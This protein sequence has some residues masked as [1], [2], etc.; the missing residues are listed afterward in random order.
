[1]C[2]ITTPLRDKFRIKHIINGGDT[3]AHHP[4]GEDLPQPEP[5]DQ[6]AH[7]RGGGHGGQ[8]DHPKH[9]AKLT[10]GGSFALGLKQGLLSFGCNTVIIY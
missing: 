9:G 4:K 2:I 5:G 7:E 1:M 6:R 10:G 8:V 3:E